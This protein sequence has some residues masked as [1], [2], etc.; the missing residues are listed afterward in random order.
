MPRYF[1]DFTDIVAKYRKDSA[2]RRARAG[3]P[4]CAI[5]FRT[6]DGVH[7]RNLSRRPAE[8]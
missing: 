2:D 6:P 8:G 5:T 4:F 7:D 1:F 3:G